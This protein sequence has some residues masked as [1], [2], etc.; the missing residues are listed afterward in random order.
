MV[1]YRELWI[2]I[3]I[4][5]PIN[6]DYFAIKTMHN[7]ALDR[8]C[9]VATQVTGEQD[10]LQQQLIREPFQHVRVEEIQDDHKEK[11]VYQKTV[12]NQ[13]PAT[14]P[15]KGT[16]PAP[17]APS[18]CFSPREMRLHTDPLSKTP[19]AS[20]CAARIWNNGYGDQCG[21][22]PRNGSECCCQHSRTKIAKRYTKGPGGSCPECS[23]AASRPIVHQHGWEHLGRFSDPLSHGPN[24]KCHH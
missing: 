9:Q 7:P 16:A 5:F 24:W 19:T 20:R 14:P 15:Y 18:V 12:F 10:R 8:I 17:M 21:S 2:T 11:N 22:K 13:P 1:W 4:D 6:Q 23:R 3:K